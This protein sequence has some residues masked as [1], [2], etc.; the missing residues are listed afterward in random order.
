MKSQGI[1]V[2][3]AVAAVALMASSQTNNS[4]IAS[5]GGSWVDVTA[6][7]DMATTPTYPGDTQPKFEF[8]RSFPKD[9]VTLSSY[10][11]TAHAGTHVDAPLH[12][13]ARGASIDQVPLATLMGRARVIDCTPEALAIDAAELNKH[14]WRG[15]ERILFRTRNSRN[16]WMVDRNFHED[17]TYLAP[18]AAQLMADA[19]VKLVGIDYLS[20]EKFG[21]PEAKTHQILLG[22]N[23]PIVEGL[24]LRGVKA[25][26]YDFIILPLKVVGHEAAPARA[27]L[28]AV[29]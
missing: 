27:L 7:L 14:D 4:N 23:I 8:L 24:D 19:G 11:M 17:F 16:S 20:A 15:A 29:P 26:E 25:G 1:L 6:P 13:V 22:K 21:A 9:K 28:R 18:D 3:M 10:L 5:S 12:F 2:V